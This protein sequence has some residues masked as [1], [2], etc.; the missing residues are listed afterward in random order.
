M[1]KPCRLEL[2]NTGAWKLLGRFDAAEE[3]ATDAILNAAAQL[4]D[5]LNDPAC[6]R[7]GLCALRVSTDE[8]SRDVLM[9][10]ADRESGWRDARTGEAA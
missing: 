1:T 6:K 4:V 10:Y 8:A 9:R 7:P 5:A 2:N 3:D